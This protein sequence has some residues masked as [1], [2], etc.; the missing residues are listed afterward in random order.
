MTINDQSGRVGELDRLKTNKREPQ[1]PVRPNDL[2][3]RP[4]QM[5]RL[6]GK[7]FKKDHILLWTSSLT[8][9][10]LL[11]IVP[12]LALAFSILK[13]FGGLERASD[14][15]MPFIMQNLAAGSAEKV[16]EYLTGMIDNV[17]AGGISGVSVLA[18]FWSVTGL[19]SNIEESLNEIWGVQKGR[20]LFQRFTN[21]IVLIVMG[22]LLLSV[23][24]SALMSLPG[25]PVVNTILDF[26]PF[27]R[28]LLLLPPF[29]FTWT[30]F[31]MAYRMLPNTAVRLR[32]AVIGGVVAGTGWELA[33]LL[34]IWAAKSIFNYGPIY[35]SLAALPIFLLWIYITWLIFLCG[36]QLSYFSQHI[37]DI[38]LDID[39]ELVS[40][41]TREF[42]ALRMMLEIGKDFFQG[43]T[44]RSVKILAAHAH[45]PEQVFRDIAR[46]FTE[47]RLIVPAE[48]E[49]GPAYVPARPLDKIMLADILSC[50]R[51]SGG[52]G[53][54]PLAD[55]ETIFI[56]RLQDD[57]EK[58]LALTTKD[59]D[60]KQLIKGL[61][62]SDQPPLQ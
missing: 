14:R 52:T 48:A 9:I 41:R 36:A 20:P 54:S 32:P 6:I 31:T 43:Q 23:S 19:L 11:S 17:H 47:G 60:L 39:A 35:G 16:S 57:L 25:L 28:K 2:F 3:A 21:Y 22:P 26:L 59:L 42:A 40:Q 50:L 15:L 62:E 51:S 56:K 61:Y 49:D 18:L 8:Y 1:P 58:T 33:K 10:T 53:L 55:I 13:A 12:L 29:F 4:R 46:I 24:L 5:L 7:G 38:G 30:I 44:P 37:K 34:Y 45:I 27:G